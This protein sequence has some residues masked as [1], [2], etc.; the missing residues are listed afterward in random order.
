VSAVVAD[1][2]DLDLQPDSY[3]NGSDETGSFRTGDATFLNYY[4]SEYDY[5]EG[6]AYSNMTDTE[7]PGYE[8]QYSAVAGQGARGS[9]L[10]GVGYYST[11]YGNP[12]PTV[13]L[14][15]GGEGVELAGAYVT[16]TT[17]AYLAMRDGDAVAKKFGGPTGEDPDWFLLS[18]H[19]VTAEREVVG[20]V[21]VYLADF[22]FSD[23]AEDYIVEDWTWVDLSGLGPVVAIELTISS[24][25]SGEH[26]INTPAYF[27]IDDIT[28]ASSNSG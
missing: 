2:E 13:T 16:N 24:S 26:G 10:Y 9:E 7:T 19:G 14:P 15:N 6:F 4:E 1:F 18:I 5:W 25:D 12:P 17:Y 8:N 27:A 23:S 28:R 20:P 3:W 21:E 11:F 22:R